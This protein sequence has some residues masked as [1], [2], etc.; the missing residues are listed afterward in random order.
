MKRKLRKSLSW[1]LTVAMIFSLFCGMIPTA[2]AAS[3]SNSDNRLFSLKYS[4]TNYDSLQGSLT[5][6][7]QD[8]NQQELDRLV[9]SNYEKTNAF[10]RNTIDVKGDYAIVGISA[11]NGTF[12]APIYG[13]NSCS[14]SLTFSL[15]DESTVYLT[16]CEFD[17][18]DVDDWIETDTTIQYRIYDLQLLKMLYLAGDEEVDANTEIDDG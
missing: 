4:D 5:V 13:G 2:S 3:T 6:I 14:F 10:H 7:M 15:D 18:P 12:S 17:R 1:L 8:Q 16:V 9:V 11:T